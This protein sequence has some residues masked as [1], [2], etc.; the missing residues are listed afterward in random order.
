MWWAHFKFTRISI[1]PTILRKEFEELRVLGAFR[2]RPRGDSLCKSP[3]VSSRD[4]TRGRCE[5]AD[6]RTSVSP[7]PRDEHRQLRDC[8]LWGCSSVYFLRSKRSRG[9]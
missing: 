8:S 9:V 4:E 1:T 3:E 7:V 6:A 5:R 2:I